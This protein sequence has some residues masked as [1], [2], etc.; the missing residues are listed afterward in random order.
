MPQPFTARIYRGS[1]ANLRRLAALLRAGE[2]VAVP[3]ETVYG[4]AA[5][6]LDADACRKIFTAKGRPASDP[7]IVHLANPADLALVAETNDASQRLAK[8]F[9]PGPL[10]L[11][12]PKKDSVPAV[13]SAGLPSVA[14]RVPAH[15]LFRRLLKLAGLPLAAPSANPFGYISPTTAAHVQ[16][17]LGGKISHILDGG[18]SKIGLESTIVDLRDPKNPRLLRPGAITR[19]QIERALGCAVQHKQTAVHSERRA[20]LAPGLLARHYS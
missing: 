9:W 8:K 3:T 10:T 12:L 2:L 16:K 13:V 17:N 5:N 7:L 20:Q 19:E 18:P 14:V 1:P 15:P 4:L 6:A 11:V